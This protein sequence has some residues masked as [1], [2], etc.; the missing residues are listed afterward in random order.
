MC[1][2]TAQ[3]ALVMF[4]G[5]LTA[6]QVVAPVRDSNGDVIGSTP[7]VNGQ[8]VSSS[9]ASGTVNVTIDTI[10]QTVTTD[11]TWTGLSGIADRA[12]LHDAPIGVTTFLSPPNFR[13]FH[14]V[15]NDICAA[16]DPNCLLPP[17]GS[18]ASNP[19]PCDLNSHFCAPESGTLHDVLQLD[20]SRFGPGL[21]NDFADL[22]ATFEAGGIYLD[23]HTALDVGGEIRAQLLPV[24]DVPEPA[25]LILVALGLAGVSIRRR[26]P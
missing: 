8:P 10:A 4:A 5:T 14:E 13:F 17:V 21:F 2:S 6:A 3:A 1:A 19:V 9:S 24:T 20:S 22:L 15:I 26:K 18:T 16:S 12:H 11:A 7:T 25:T 23:F